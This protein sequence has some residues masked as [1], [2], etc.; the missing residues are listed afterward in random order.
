MNEVYFS[1]SIQH[2][3]S[4]RMLA[5][6]VLRA[7]ESEIKTL[8]SEWLFDW[9]TE[10]KKYPV[11]KLVLVEAQ[12]VVQGLMSI[13]ERRGFVFVSLIEN[14]SFNRGVDKIYRGVA[15]NLFAFACKLSAEKGFGGF[16]AFEAKSAL[17]AHYQK[18]LGALQIGNSNRMFID[19][20]QAQKLIQ[21]YFPK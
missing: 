14:V 11:Y 2:R 21:I 13:E 20:M 9:E 17:I 16:V 5:T 10:S 7:E 18:I 8:P 15:V 12:N 19:E 1:N 3:E 6:L 4:G